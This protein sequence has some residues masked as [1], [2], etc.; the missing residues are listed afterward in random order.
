MWRGI[1]TF[2]FSFRK[3]MRFSGTIPTRTDVKGRVFFPSAY[4]RQLS[5][6]EQEFVLRRDVYEPCLVVYPR[7]VWEREVDELRRRLNRWNP[8]EAMLLRQFMADAEVFGLDA[9]GRFL[10]PKRLLQAAGIVHELVFVGMDDRLELW[11][12]ERMERPFVESADF[13]AALERLMAAGG[14][15]EAADKDNPI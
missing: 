6:E 14:R 5:A 15:D 9:S 12:R 10:I 2:E 3:M 1:S 8:R 11:S 7:K 13:G 4:R